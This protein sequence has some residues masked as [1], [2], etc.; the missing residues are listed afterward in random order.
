[1][2]QKVLVEVNAYYMAFA[3][4][5][6]VPVAVG[7]GMDQI[8][9]HPITYTVRTREEFVAKVADCNR[10]RVHI[11]F[12]QEDDVVADVTFCKGSSEI[13][14][15]SIMCDSTTGVLRIP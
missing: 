11:Y 5:C 2:F 15:L 4:N 1:M 13:E 3:L 7:G 12:S 10:V 8:L 9:R 14:T 6:D